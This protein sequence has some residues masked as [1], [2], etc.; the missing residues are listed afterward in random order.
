[1]ISL[2]I[3]L[4]FKFLVVQQYTLPDFNNHHYKSCL[5]KDGQVFIPLRGGIFELTSETFFIAPNNESKF[6]LLSEDKRQ[7]KLYTVLKSQDSTYLSISSL[8]GA[9]HKHLV[10]GDAFKI[11]IG[12][13]ITLIS[14]ISKDGSCVYVCE[15]DD[16]IAKLLELN[17]LVITDMS[18]RKDLAYFLINDALFAFNLETNEYLELFQ[19]SNKPSGIAAI[20]DDL[21]LISNNK[22]LLLYNLDSKKK[23]K[24]IETEEYGSLTQMDDVVI[25]HSYKSSTIFILDKEKLINEY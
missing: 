7:D 10:D 25:L 2:L 5:I 18:S 13:S 4:L 8:S 3:I 11:N 6:L 14:S 9:E 17:D 16:T 12:D 21:L 23:A 19:I 20:S 15:E 1:M 24:F 22:G